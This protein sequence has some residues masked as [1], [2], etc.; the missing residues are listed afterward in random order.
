MTKHDLE[1]FS[2]ILT[3]T[4]SSLFSVSSW[5]EISKYIYSI[6]TPPIFQMLLFIHIPK[7][8]QLDLT[9]FDIS[10]YFSTCYLYLVTRYSVWHKGKI[11]WRRKETDIDCTV[12]KK[13]EDIHDTHKEQT[14]LPWY[15]P[16]KRLPKKH[17][18]KILSTEWVSLPFLLVISG[19]F[20]VKEDIKFIIL[21][22]FSDLFK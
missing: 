14:S 4:F 5:H 11:I 19:S 3:T 21:C 12:V 7:W 20:S 16:K 22:F 13:V 1:T 8:S 17:F 9:R 18:K 10:S 15:T 6:Y 2:I